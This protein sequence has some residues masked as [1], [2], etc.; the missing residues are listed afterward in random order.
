MKLEF[1][2][3]KAELQALPR[4]RVAKRAATWAA[5]YAPVEP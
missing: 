2:S 3:V 5:Y 1:A 4:A